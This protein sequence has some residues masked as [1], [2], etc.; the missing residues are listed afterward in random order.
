MD[1]TGKPM[2]GWV[3]VGGPALVEDKVLDHWIALAVG[4]AS[5]CR[6][7]K[8]AVPVRRLRPVHSGLPSPEACA[9]HADGRHHYVGR[10]VI[11]AEGGDPG[12]DAWTETSSG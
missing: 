7:S 6:P 1:F 4:S 5:S 2:R 10:L 8:E 11:R 9:A 3:T 12:S